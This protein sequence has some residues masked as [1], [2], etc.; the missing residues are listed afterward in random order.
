VAQVRDKRRT[1]VNIRRPRIPSC[2]GLSPSIVLGCV[3]ACVRTGPA[4][5]TQGHTAVAGKTLSAFRGSAKCRDSFDQPRD[6]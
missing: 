3:C 6:C 2:P 1:V 5:D 4:R